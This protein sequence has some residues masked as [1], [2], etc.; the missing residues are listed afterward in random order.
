MEASLLWCLLFLA[1]PRPFP[2]FLTLVFDNNAVW[3][4]VTSLSVVLI[5]TLPVALNCIVLPMIC[6]QALCTPT[7][8]LN[9]IQLK[10]ISA[11]T[12]LLEHRIIHCTFL[13]VKHSIYIGQ[14]KRPQMESFNVYTLHVPLAILTFLYLQVAN[15]NRFVR[16]F[17][18]M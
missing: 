13:E 9:W 12:L 11:T 3:V 7:L 6:C 16:L 15:I 1:V 8:L 10:I 4:P 18:H 5:Q 2:L 17:L 14:S